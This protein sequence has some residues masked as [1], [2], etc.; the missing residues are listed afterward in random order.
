ME[1]DSVRTTSSISY[2]FQLGESDMRFIL[3][4]LKDERGG[5]ALEHGT[6]T[7]LVAVTSIAGYSMIS[8]SISDGLV[9]ASDQ[10]SDATQNPIGG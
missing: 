7:V 6:I 4:F 5:E 9:V 2:D 8:E 10:I 1:S 3:D